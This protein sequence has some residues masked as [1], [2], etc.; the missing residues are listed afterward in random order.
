MQNRVQVHAFAAICRVRGRLPFSLLGIDSDNG[1]EFIN[2]QL[3][4]YCLDEEIP[5]TRGRAGKKNGSAYVEQENWSVVRRAVGYRLCTVMHFYVNFL[6]M[7]ELKDKI[8]VG[9]KIKKTYDDPLTPYARA[10][11]CSDV[12]DE[13]KAQLCETYNHL[14]L[15]G[16]RR[17]INQLQDQLL[18]SV[19][20]L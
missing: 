10:L 20:V 18:D 12:S 6:P 19:S 15:V 3:Y 14:N 8:R 1:A 7:M 2:D 11:A 13:Q 9:S 16:L 17:Q 4:R 5:F